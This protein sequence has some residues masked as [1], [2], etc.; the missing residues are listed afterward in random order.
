VNRKLII[1]VYSN[2]I[3]I[4]IHPSVTDD[5]NRMAKMNDDHVKKRKREENDDKADDN[6]LVQPK[7]L[8]ENDEKADDPK[9]VDGKEH[10]DNNMGRELIIV[11]DK[12]VLPKLYYVPSIKL[13]KNDVTLLEKIRVQGFSK[14]ESNKDEAQL[15]E[16]LGEYKIDVKFGV[17]Y[18]K[19]FGI[20][21]SY[22]LL[23]SKFFKMLKKDADK[24]EN[25]KENDDDNDDNALDTSPN[26]IRTVKCKY[27]FNLTYDE[28]VKLIDKFDEMS[29]KDAN[30]E[31]AVKLLKKY[32]I[33][34]RHYHLEYT[35]HCVFHTNILEAEVDA[36][37]IC[38]DDLYCNDEK[39][40][41]GKNDGHGEKIKDKFANIYCEDCI[42][43][44]MENNCCAFCGGI[45]KNDRCTG[46]R[47]LED[48]NQID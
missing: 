18:P 40:E 12:N 13:D 29:E 6:E 1:A 22:F 17:P 45:V 37:I 4:L 20:I 48:W 9:S 7:Y 34:E 21:N 39:N 44:A 43:E 24:N 2:C 47:L 31:L 32:S 15:F 11:F 25:H 5:T 26:F 10:N 42:K 23:G 3:I 28:A 27:L 41:N 14:D 8:K 46:S 38:N 33:P 16:K 19:L 35:C 30:Y 36:C